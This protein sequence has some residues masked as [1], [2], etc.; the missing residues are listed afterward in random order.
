MILQIHDNLQVSDVQERF[1]KCFPYLKIEFYTRAHHIGDETPEKFM[2]DRNKRIG[3]IRRNKNAGCLEIK[4]WFTVS[5][6]EKDFKELFGLNVQV[7]RSENDEWVQ[8]SKTDNRSLLQQTE[9]ARH[10]ERCL[11]P[12]Y[13][14]QLGEYEYL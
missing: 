12:K 4:S 11:T 3:E 1:S 7:F 2:V 5:R 10:A 13:S 14:E 6:I 8:T 9:M